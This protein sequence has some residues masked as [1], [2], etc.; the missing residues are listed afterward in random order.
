MVIAVAVGETAGYILKVE[1]QDLLV[2]ECGV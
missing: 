1:A 2:I